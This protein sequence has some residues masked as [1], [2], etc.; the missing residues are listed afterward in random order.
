VKDE[1]AVYMFVGQRDGRIRIFRA[2]AP[3]RVKFSALRFAET[4]FLPDIRMNEHSS[5]FVQ[6][7]NG[8]FDI[9]S[10]DYSGNLRHF[11]C[12]NNGY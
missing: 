6:L 9:M 12:K 5:P 1:K 2:D 8:M 10:G 4:G 3:G 7:N 11:L